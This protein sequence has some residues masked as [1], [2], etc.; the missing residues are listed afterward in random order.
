[1]LNITLSKKNS[2]EEREICFV[3][4]IIKEMIANFSFSHS[5]LKRSVQMI[6][7]LVSVKTLL[8]ARIS[9]DK[10]IL[11]SVWVDETKTLLRQ[12]FF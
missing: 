11:A 9:F 10:F 3:A 12:P 7:L 4:L 5:L 6:F 2:C 8:I 1:M